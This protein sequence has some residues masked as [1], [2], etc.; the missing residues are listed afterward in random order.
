MRGI[1]LRADSRGGKSH[2]AGATDRQQKRL[3]PP[4]CLALGAPCWGTAP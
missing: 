1:A 3:S 4:L 2:L